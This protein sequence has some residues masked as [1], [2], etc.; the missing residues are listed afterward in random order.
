MPWAL[1]SDELMP[2]DDNSLLGMCI[3]SSAVG[4]IAA[5]LS[6]SLPLLLLEDTGACGLVCDRGLPGAGLTSVVTARDAVATL[7]TSEKEEL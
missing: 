4:P 7:L 2:P 6:P 5:R 1:D 3:S